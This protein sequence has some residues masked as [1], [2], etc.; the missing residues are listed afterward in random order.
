V[1]GR[2]GRRRK[3]QLNYLK[4]KQGYCELK[5]EA[6]GHTVWRTGYGRGNGSNV[7]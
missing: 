4:E 1:K 5:E 7:R 3:Q 6:V 2:R